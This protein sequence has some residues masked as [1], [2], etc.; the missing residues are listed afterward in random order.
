MFE[1]LKE[2]M[3]NSLKEKTNKNWKKS[4]NPLKKTKKKAIKQMKET[5]KRETIKK[6]QTE[7]IIE[8]EIMKKFSGITN[9]SLKS[10]IQ[11]MEERLSSAEDTI[12][13]I[14]SLV[15]EN[16]KSNKSLTQ[17]SQEIWNTIK[18]PN[19]RIIG[20]EE[21]EAQLKSTENVFHKIIAE[22][23]P[24]QKKDI[25]MKTQEAYRTPNKSPRAT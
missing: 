4:T 10:R 11:Q 20:I 16:I 13:K 2:E 3:K 7:E 17:N 12:E 19:I 5:I 6:T 14:D 15:K 22:I 21:G 9:T 8:M 24:N 1:A 18:R 23:F 25:H